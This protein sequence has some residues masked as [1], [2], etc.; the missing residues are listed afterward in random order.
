MKSKY[1]AVF[2]C[3]F[4]IFSSFI[5]FS[6][7]QDEEEDQ[8]LQNVDDQPPP[9]TEIKSIEVDEEDEEIEVEP[10]QKP[11]ISDF[12]EEEFVGFEESSPQEKVKEKLL[13]ELKTQEEYKKVF[14]PREENDYY[15]EMI[16]VG[17][18]LFYLIYFFYGRSQNQNIALRW[19]KHVSPLL[20]LQFTK[21][22]GNSGIDYLLK[23][24]NNVFITKT[25]GRIHCVGAQFELNLKK[26]H[27]LLSI[28]I[29][30]ISPSQDIL[31]I[32]V[33]M[34]ANFM[35]PF[36][37]AVIRRKNEKK[38]R[39]ENRDMSLAKN[40]T[41]FHNLP[42]T[43]VCLSEIEE[44]KTEFLTPELVNILQQHENEFISLHFSDQGLVSPRF[45][46]TLEFT[47]VLPKDPAVLDSLMNMVFTLIDRVARFKPSKSGKEALI[48]HR[49]KLL[50]EKLKAS[51]KEKEKEKEENPSKEK[52]TPEQ[53]KKYEEKMQKKELKKR[54]PKYK[55]IT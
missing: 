5:A 45:A 38:F 32:T 24:S 12:D 9:Q 1:L 22:Y 30:F 15:L 37:F 47:F 10:I 7:Q 39:K 42:Q 54:Q 40:A 27:D 29:G 23:E 21:I 11:N 13:K 46:H 19:M 53:Q 44:L 8:I 34:Q 25:T 31:K 52:L 55:I 4:L 50:D 49:L 33:L 51:E 14:V 18:I 20:K 48:K 41:G 26:R 17:I 36:V 43:L 3:F 16:F 35:E 6:F 28:L 2:F